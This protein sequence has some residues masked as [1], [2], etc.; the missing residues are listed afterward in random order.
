MHPAVMYTIYNRF[1]IA[2][3]A[4]SPVPIVI[5]VVL[6]ASLAFVIAVVLI[7]RLRMRLFTLLHVPQATKRIESTAERIV[8]SLSARLSPR[9]S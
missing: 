5:L 3:F 8:T 1:S 9:E 6:G 2:G 7:D 4:T